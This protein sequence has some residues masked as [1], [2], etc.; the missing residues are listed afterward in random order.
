M[1][2]NCLLLENANS[3]VLKQLEEFRKKYIGGVKSEKK[4]FEKQTAKFC[5]NQ[6]RYLNKTTKNPNTLQ[7]ADASVDMAE[8]HFYAASMDYVYL[9]QEVHERKKFEFVET[10]L[11]FVYAYFTFYHQGHEIKKDFDPFMKDLQS[12]IQ[13]TRTNFDDFSEKLKKRM[14]EVQKQEVPP[15]ISKGCKEGYLF[16]LEKSKCQQAIC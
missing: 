9:I 3:S 16:L 7:E 10:L 1:V 13:K 6:E 2:V 4:K 5:Q 15:S 12:K 8:R 14:S 11:T